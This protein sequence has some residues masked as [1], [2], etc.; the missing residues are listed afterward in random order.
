MGK[1]LIPDDLPSVPVPSSFPGSRAR[2]IRVTDPLTK[3]SAKETGH[4]QKAAKPVFFM[5]DQDLLTD[6]LDSSCFHSCHC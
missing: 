2:S 1:P 3:N 4:F 5:Q 6:Y